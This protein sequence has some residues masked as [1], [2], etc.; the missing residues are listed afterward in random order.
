MSKANADFIRFDARFSGKSGHS[1]LG[2]VLAGLRPW[3]LSG[4][5]A[6][7][8]TLGC[9]TQHA[10][11]NIGAP[12]TAVAGSPFT[13]TVTAMVGGSRDRIINSPIHFT[14]SDRAAVLPGDY[15]FTANDAGSHT[16]TNGV[17]LMTAGSQSITATA[18]GAFGLNG[19]ANVTVSATT[20]A[21]HEWVHRILT[22]RKYVAGARP[23]GWTRTGQL[24]IRSV[25][26]AETFLS[27][28]LTSAKSNGLLG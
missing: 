4:V 6:G 25:E 7:F 8:V 21:T 26:T 11:L 22:Q 16:F 3:A 2:R 10:T 14:S 28:K 13:V 23:L 17:T 20:A 18:F 15:Y 19:T 24:A 9:G 12:S 1:G 5:V 27:R